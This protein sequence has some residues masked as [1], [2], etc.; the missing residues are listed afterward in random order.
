[1]CHEHYLSQRLNKKA[2]YKHVFVIIT[3]WGQNE[4]CFMYLESI[5]NNNHVL[6][7]NM[8]CFVDE[9]FTVIINSRLIKLDNMKWIAI[10]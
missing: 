10:S 5:V 1:M 8:L 3:F 9:S 4:S 2:A 7:A 6:C